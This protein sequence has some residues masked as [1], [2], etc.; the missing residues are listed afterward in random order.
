MTTTRR[1]HLNQAKSPLMEAADAVERRTPWERDYDR[2]LFSTPV[3]RLADKTQVFPLEKHDSVRTRLTHSHEV[4]NLARGMGTFLAYEFKE[5]RDIEKCARTIPPILAAIGL[6]HDL[7]NPPFGHQ[8][9]RAIQQWFES[10]AASLFEPVE[11]I[12]DSARQDIGK[13]TLAMRNDFLKF[14][15]NAQTFRLLTR[16]QTVTND[17]GIN[18]TLATLAAVMKYPIASDQTKDGHAA[19]KKHGYFQSEIDVIKTVF[20]HTGLDS[21][22]R[23]PLAW[24]MEACDDIA[25]SVLDAEDSIKK[26]LV[27]VSDLFA[28]LEAEAPNDKLVKDLI[29]F[30]RKT[31]QETRKYGLSPAELNDSTI[32]RFRVNAIGLMVGAVQ[33][34]FE[35]NYE[36]IMDGTL[37]KDLLAKSDAGPLAAALKKF[38]KVHAYRHPSV[39]ALELRGYN[40]IYT[41]MDML[42]EGITRRQSYDDPASKRITPFAEF[43]YSRISENYRR[44]FEGKV[45]SAQHLPIRYREAQLL[46]D[47]VSG[48]T[49]GYA[50]ELCN[51]LEGFRVG[52]SRS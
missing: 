18:L 39:L 45:P 17:R 31:H 38:D 2:V 23:H 24:L 52:P 37:D 1:S 49:D 20:E 7:G 33:K 25:Y 47:M 48:M 43:A 44:I 15:G 3:R 29:D 8:G 9:E 11:G 10:N 19:T 16:L 51:E 21:G 26:S 41:L 14:E 6:A 34:A 12:S 42:W 5:T 35:D 30:G 22:V 46:T 40:T 4:S 32:Q 27:S 36:R 28:Y 50:I 13:L